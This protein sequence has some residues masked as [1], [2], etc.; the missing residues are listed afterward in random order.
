MIRKVFNKLYRPKMH[1]IFGKGEVLVQA[2][3]RAGKPILIL[4]H[5]ENPGIPGENAAAKERSAIHTD[6]MRRSIVLEF[7]SES[8]RD[9]VG[10]A[11]MGIRK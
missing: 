8:H 10:D 3:S 4:S 11:M 9:A 6:V 2:G 1:F 5:P 7:P